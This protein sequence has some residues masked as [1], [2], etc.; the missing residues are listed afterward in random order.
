MI[1]LKTTQMESYMNFIEGKNCFVCNTSENVTGIGL[2]IEDITYFGPACLDK[3]CRRQ[4][5]KNVGGVTTTARDEG[6]IIETHFH[7]INGNE[8]L[9]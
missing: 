4:A 8:N 5:I 6:K 1:T 2:R 7:A 9:I 3:H